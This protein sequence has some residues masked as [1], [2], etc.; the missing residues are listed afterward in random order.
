MINPIKTPQEMLMQQ[1][2]L[3]SYA[4]GRS[5]S[6]EQMKVELMINGKPVH[7]EHLAHD[8]PLIQHFA[9][10]SAVLSS[11]PVNDSILD[12]IKNA[13]PE[14]IKKYAGTTL[15]HGLMFGEPIYDTGK[16]L[17]NQ[18]YPEAAQNAYD[19]ASSWNLP[20]ILAF[21]ARDLNTGEDEQ[22]KAMH[23]RMK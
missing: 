6:P 18:N 14:P 10:G 16:A 15:L 22:L 17:L 11:K 2:G 21:H 20:R 7:T 9:G 4:E 23:E 8:H 19:V 12:T 3:P 13:I 1:A 5:V